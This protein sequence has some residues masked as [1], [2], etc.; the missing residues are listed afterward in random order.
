MHMT[1]F[2]I[3]KMSV[4]GREGE[5]LE[6][7]RYGLHT[8][9]CDLLGCDVPVVL[10][11]MGG[12]ARA[13]LV[14][15]VSAAGGYGILGM[16]RESP[17]FIRRQI[18]EVRAQTEKDFGVNL[19]PAATPRDLFLK[20]LQVCLE[21]RVHSVC[22]F[23]DLDDEVI[24]RLRDN[25]ILVICQVGSRQEAIQAL[26]A[27]AQ[28]LIA[29]G[30]E[31]GGHVRGTQA[32][33]KLLADVVSLE[34]DEPILTAGGIA[35]GADLADALN[36]GA[37]GIVMGTSFLVTQEAFAHDYHKGRIVEAS[38]SDI[39]YTQDFHIN[40]PRDAYVRVLRN[41]VTDGDYGDPFSSERQI[42]GEDSGRVLYRFG[43]DSPLQSTIGKLEQMALYAGTGA[44]AI[45]NIP[46][47]AE[48]MGEILAEAIDARR[49]AIPQKPIG[50]VESIDLASPSCTATLA[51]N[52]YMG[53]MAHEEVVNFLNI[54]L[55]AERAGA[56]AAVRL[57]IDTNDRR[58]SVEMRET[59][60]NEVYCCRLLIDE[61]DALGAKV[62]PRIGDFYDKLMAIPSIDERVV[63]LA[64]GQRWVARKIRENLPKIRSDRLHLMLAEMLS[65]HDR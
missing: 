63:F 24:L 28:I 36:H 44:A 22:L 61:L 18:H 43:T 19:I 39:I 10:A 2:G 53:F 11:G 21:E 48:R 65:L 4:R 60:A 1:I 31:S 30:V 42:I 8:K 16:V 41:S 51:G 37:A 27:G 64:K 59:H 50:E 26:D 46:T 3:G 33:L 62:S 13:N 55:E 7:M 54:L 52:E 15:A 38:P 34:R 20:E 25:E 35:R 40:W 58:Q 57:A 17:E 45:S 47:A 23:W 12:V 5:R 56:R 32:R 6:L 29:Q 14:S 49:E 9:V